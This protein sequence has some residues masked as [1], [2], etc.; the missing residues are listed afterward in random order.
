MTPTSPPSP[1]PP[2]DAEQAQA[3]A[4]LDGGLLLLAP[5][6]SGKTRTLADRVVRALGAGLEARRVLCLTFTNRAAEEMRARVRARAGEAGRGVQVSTFHGLCARIVE[7]EHRR[8]G[9]PAD[10]TIVDEDDADELLRRAGAPAERG[11]LQRLRGLLAAAKSPPG[12]LDHADARL[13]PAAGPEALFRGLPG[14]ERAVLVAYQ[15]LLAEQQAVDFDD[16][17]RLTRALLRAEPGLADAWASRFDLVQVDEVQDAHESEYEVVRALA[18]GSGRLALIGDVDQT[19]Y[20]WRGSEPRRVLEAFRRDFAPVRTIT[21]RWNHRATRRLVR[22]ADAVLTGLPERRTRVAPAPHLEEGEPAVLHVAR[23]PREEG[24]WIAARVR[25]LAAEGLPW[26]R[27]GVLA[28]TNGRTRALSAALAEAAVPHVTVEAF[29]FFRRQEVKD[30]V[31]LL[32]LLARP[33][34]AAAAERLLRRPSRGLGDAG[35]ARLRSA[36]DAA[37]LRV[38]DLLGPGALSRGD[39]F[40]RLLEA[41]EAGGLVV[42][43]T[44]TTG[45]SP[46]HDEVVE[47]GAAPLVAGEE[48]AAFQALVRPGRPVGASVQTHGLTDERLARE[49]RPAL[50][51][52]QELDDFAGARPVVG[53]NVAFDLAMLEAH[54]QRAGHAPRFSARFDTL[55]LSRR[56]LDLPRHDLGAVRA[57]LGLPPGRAHRAL[58]DARGA[59]EVLRRLAPALRQGSAE[60]A[61]LLAGLPEGVVRLARGLADLRAR[62]RH[63]RPAALLRE[64]LAVS[65]LHAFYEREPER[66]ANLRDLLATLERRDEPAHA[67]AEALRDAVRY[68]TLA[69]TLALETVVDDRVPVVTVHQAKGLEFEAVLVAGVVDDE[70]P[71]FLAARE[72]GERLAEEQRLFYVAVTRARRR[73]LLSAHA[74]GDLGHRRE[75]SRYLR[76]IAPGDLERR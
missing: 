56:L 19:I 40:A 23:T 51:V 20:G 41:L 16:L 6:G 14:P 29:E 76:A 75:E 9:L 39:P 30:A 31:A 35:L 36:G 47:V 42:L 48:A 18:R 43:D 66:L 60:R 27:I 74:R 49:G 58:D 64:G 71:H 25:A 63:L 53:H 59:A 67:P 7:A 37:G 55:D 1:D 46:A 32:R 72:G 4:H 33:D 62:A 22:I 70:F 65:G 52:L 2:P 17:V 61:R 5:V 73:L 8:L 3:L 26:A 50:D 54:G 44:E 69:R 10:V 34:D 57:H 13:H 11:E 68:A 15:R 12:S 24:A 38:S 21:L 45:L 28:R